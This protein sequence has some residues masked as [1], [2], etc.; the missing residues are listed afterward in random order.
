M[1]P[2]TTEHE[3]LAGNAQMPISTDD[4]ANPQA[5]GNQATQQDARQ[6]GDE[7]QLQETE[8]E[9]GEAVGLKVWPCGH[10]D[11]EK[12]VVLK[13]WPFRRDEAPKPYME[14]LATFQHQVR[15]GLKSLKSQHVCYDHIEILM[16]Y[17]KG[18]DMPKVAEKAKDVGSFLEKASYNFTVTPI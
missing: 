5:D 13:V 18:S 1:T 11:D 15:E 4:S 6:S 12:P 7:K 2:N 16:V 8:G 14:N 3:S 17:W 10:D 9:D